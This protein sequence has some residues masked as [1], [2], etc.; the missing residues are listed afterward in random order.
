[1][2]GF[3]SIEKLR[4]DHSLDSFENLAISAGSTV[5]AEATVVA[6]AVE[7]PEFCCVAMVGSPPLIAW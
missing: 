5:V 4:R 2:S 3:G 7:G 1:M 6:A